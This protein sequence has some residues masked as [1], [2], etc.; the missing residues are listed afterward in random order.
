MPPG[1]TGFDVVFGDLGT[2]HGSGLAASTLGSEAND[3]PDPTLLLG[4][5]PAPGAGTWYLVRVVTP[6]GNGSYTSDG[7]SEVA[8][9]DAA[10][11]MTGLECP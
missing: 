11:A 7:A 9:R 4:A 1:A 10:I 8:G 2:L 3:H 5:D 6:S